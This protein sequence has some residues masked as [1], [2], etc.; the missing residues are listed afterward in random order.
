MATKLRLEAKETGLIA[1]IGDEDTATGFL[2][3][4]I[5]DRSSKKGPNFFVVE[6]DKKEQELGKIV[7]AFKH[8]TTRGDISILLINQSVADEIRFVLHEYNQM[9]P[10]VLEIPSKDNPYDETRDPI[11]LRVQK[12]LGKE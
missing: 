12:L 3:A 9:T 2:L 5:G 7:D 8:F 10:T 6:K 1:V 11:F 4:G